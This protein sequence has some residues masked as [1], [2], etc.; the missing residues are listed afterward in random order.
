[1][2]KAF[3]DDLPRERREPGVAERYSLKG[4]RKALQDLQEQ[5]KSARVMFGADEQGIHEVVQEREQV[6]V[7]TGVRRVEGTGG[8]NEDGDEMGIRGSAKGSERGSQGE[9]SQE[10]SEEH[11]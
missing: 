10:R 9:G 5:A 8:G 2:W 1:M 7:A 4:A 11:V 6:E 3:S